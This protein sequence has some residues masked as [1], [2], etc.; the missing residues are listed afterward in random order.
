MVTS[1]AVVAPADPADARVWEED[2]EVLEPH[3]AIDDVPPLAETA[4]YA[5][6]HTLVD[7]S[8]FVLPLVVA[9]AI[10]YDDAAAAA[11]VSACLALMGLF[12]FVNATW[13]HRLPSVMGPS[14]T[15][16]AAMA[17]V[18]SVFGAPAMWGAAAVG[19]LVEAA[20]GAS[21]ALGALRRFLPPHV[22]GLVV[23][24]IGLTLGRV[25]AGW[26]F[27]D[28]RPEMLGL[29]L[30]TAAS[31][32]ALTVA[33]GRF[34]LGVLARGAIVVSLLL[35]GVVA[36]VGLGLADFTPLA[37]APWLALPRLMPF[38]G[39][40][41]GWALTAGALFGIL[42]GYVGSI[43]ESIGDYA[44]TCAVS[45]VTY[46]VRHM[47]RGITVEGLASAVAPLFGAIPLTTY[48]QN[49]GVIAT[50]RV[51]SRRVVQVA[52]GILLLY[53]LCP[54]V[55]ALLLVL[56]RPVVGVVFMVVCGMIAV[57]GV[58]LLA[59]GVKDEAWL[60]TTAL[61]LAVALT[62]PVVAPAQGEWFAGLHP[63]ARLFLGNAVVLATVL[64][65][66]LNALLRT[67]LAPRG[68]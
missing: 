48:S 30:A 13:G 57:A 26:V 14:A 28:P 41:L 22:C 39:P 52:A 55:A 54:K 37:A 8:P 63:F 1:S 11:M 47:R 61:T 7:V 27:A 49:T 20:V 68:G 59:C 40:G 44:G 53:G 6:Q 42:A 25:A 12:T 60:L 46:T 16:T 45:R 51:A 64:A 56:P 34:G 62:V 66:G 36:A 3:Y 50:T 67:T 65:V 43:A 23:L 4:L 38:G 24:T 58:R 9:R 19:G 32:V 21:G 10:G 35:W 18:G 31:I 15:M 2:L 5:W 33:G 29:G 17:S